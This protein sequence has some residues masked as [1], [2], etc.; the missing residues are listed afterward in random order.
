[1]TKQKLFVQYGCG[2]SAPAGWL[3]FDA[4]PTLRLQRLPFGVG[5]LLKHYLS[6]RFPENVRYGDIVHGLP[7]MGDSCDA[8]YCSH[9]LEHLSL[10]DFS[11]ALRETYRI[12]KPGGIFRLVVPDLEILVKNYFSDSSPDAAVRFIKAT[13]LGLEKR[14]RNILEFTKEFL[15][16]SRHLWLWDER[17]LIKALEKTN[18]EDCRRAQFGDSKEKAFQAVEDKSRWEGCLGI[19][20]KKPAK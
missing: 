11:L 10:Q 17:S 8:V 5:T 7:I 12:L 16:N 20:C 14:S 19:E 6:P 15:G 9:I 13:G 2:L 4:S 18:F 1:M 3:N